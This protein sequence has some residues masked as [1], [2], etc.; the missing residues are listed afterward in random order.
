MNIFQRK[1]EGIS[2]SHKTKKQELEVAIQNSLKD[3]VTNCIIYAVYQ[4]KTSD[5]QEDPRVAMGN[6]RIFL[7][8]VFL[9]ITDMK[10]H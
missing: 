5:V 3:L 1:N 9:L 2:K 6:S 7:Q 10:I 4:L 8:S